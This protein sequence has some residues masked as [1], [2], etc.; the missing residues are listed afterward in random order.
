MNRECHIAIRPRMPVDANRAAGL[1]RRVRRVLLYAA[2]AFLLAHVFAA[3]QGADTL[4]LGE[5][6]AVARATA[7]APAL[8]RGEA[9]LRRARAGHTKA[10]TILPAPAELEYSTTSD[11]PFEARGDGG[12]ELSLTQEFEIGGQRSLRRAAAD[13]DIGRAEQERLGAIAE[14]RLETRTAFAR[15]IEAED[16]LALADTMLLLATAMEDAAERLYAAGERSELD[17]NTVRIDRAQT[18]SRRLMA[19]ADRLQAQAEL[20]R[21]IGAPPAT[22]IVTIRG[23]ELDAA[24]MDSVSR[25][26]REALA[27]STAG[28]DAPFAARPDLL[29]LRSDS[30]RAAAELALGGRRWVPNLRLGALLR[31]DRVS[32][33]EGDISPADAGPSPISRISSS[34]KSFG[35]RV[36]LSLPIPI[37][38]LYDLGSGDIERA[39]ADLAGVA[40]ERLVLRSAAFA[41]LSAVA[42][43]LRASADAVRLYRDDVEPLARRNRELLERGYR[44][45]ELAAVQVITQKQ[46][47]AQAMETSIAAEREYR[48]A[49]ATFDRILGR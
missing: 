28:D 48:E 16:R 9:A 2:P 38:G 3:A 12:W 30:A 44:E 24:A 45:G 43:R 13:A 31:G 42:A 47:L 41:E 33:V 25:R 46:Q 39:E 6:D 36:G 22:A 10:G 29:A 5:A 26:V 21:L 27:P 20:K 34:D 7:S 17:R 1:I 23:G 15:L 19:E 14:L 8:A 18:A 4:R 32:F 49:C 40:A 35:V 37:A 11:A